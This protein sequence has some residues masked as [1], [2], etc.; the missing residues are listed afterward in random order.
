MKSKPRRPVV[1]AYHLIWTNYGTWLPNDPRGSGSQV[2]GFDELADLGPVHYGRKKIQPPSREIR[3]FYE[4]AE[5]LLRFPVIRFDNMQRDLVAQGL[6][7]TIRERQYTCYACAIMPDHVHILIRKHRDKAEEMIDRLQTASR[8]RLG[9]GEAIDST[10]PIWTLGGWKR[11]LDSQHAIRAVIKYIENNP[12]KI[13]LPRQH[14][15]FVSV[16]D[17]WP[18]S[19]GSRSE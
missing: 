1:L 12:V 5:R 9:K 3:E 16:Y 15:S 14:W 18:R 6:A 8:L 10:H 17:G 13:G 19:I 11:F 2:V 7:E 4:K